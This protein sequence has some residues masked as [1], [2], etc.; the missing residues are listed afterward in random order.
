MSLLIGALV[1][2]VVVILLLYLVNLLPIDG[3][4]KQVVR[5]IVVI[6]GILPLLKY[7]VV[8]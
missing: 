4:I 1:T 3:R 5:V 2:F 7:I 8:F 6:I